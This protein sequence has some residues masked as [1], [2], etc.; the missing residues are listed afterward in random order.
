MC[1]LHEWAD[2]YQRRLD[3][4]AARAR[5]TLREY[6]QGDHPLVDPALPIDNLAGTEF[7]TLSVKRIRDADLSFAQRHELITYLLGAWFADHVGGEWIYVPMQVNNHVLYL[8][9]GVGIK[10]AG[11]LWNT[12]ESARDVLAGEDLALIEAMILVSIRTSPDRHAWRDAQE[13]S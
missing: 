10:D 9:F 13:N 7:P 8:K 11:M 6:Q 3:E 1:T 12:A 5:A 4:L 2:G